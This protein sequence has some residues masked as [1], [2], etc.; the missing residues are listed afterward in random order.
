MAV[1]TTF[2]CDNCGV[3]KKEVNHWFMLSI[4]NGTDSVTVYKWDKDADSLDA[5]V[6]GVD[7]AVRLVARWMTTGKL[8]EGGNAS[9]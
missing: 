1:V 2:R 5:H 7:C 9:S 8:L 3:L 4:T 6:C